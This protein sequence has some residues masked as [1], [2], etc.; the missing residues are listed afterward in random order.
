MKSLTK[1]ILIAA[2]VVLLSAI[3]FAILTPQRSKAQQQLV[4]NTYSK[5][6]LYSNDGKV[7]GTWTA[8]GLGQRDGNTF[9]FTVYRGVGV[10]HEWQVRINGT[11]TVEQTAP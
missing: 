1:K 11:F 3:A 9:T 8:I 7:I 5:V 10:T 4:G 6:T 2:C